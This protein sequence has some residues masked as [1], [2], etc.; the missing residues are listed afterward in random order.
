MDFDLSDMKTAEPKVNFEVLVNKIKMGKA[1]LFTGAGFSFGATNSLGHEPMGAKELSRFISKDIGL[2]ENDNL[3]FTSD[4]FLSKKKPAELIR[5]LRDNFTITTTS[6]T[7]NLICELPWRRA[8]TT[9]YDLSI[10]LAS[11]QSSKRFETIDIQQSYGEVAQPSNLLCVHLNGSIN[12]LTEESLNNSFKLSSSSYVSPDSFLNSEWNYGFKRDLERAD[13]ILFVGYSL[14]D[15]DIQR[16]LHEDESLRDKTYFVTIKNPDVETEFTLSKYGTVLPIGTDAFAE[17]IE[18]FKTDDSSYVDYSLQCFTRYEISALKPE[19]RDNDVEKLLLYGDIS[20]ASV[21][22]CMLNETAV[23][24]LVKRSYLSETI[25]ALNNGRNI[26][27]Y[28]G[29]GN[30]KT[31]LLNEL[32]VEMS[33]RDFHVYTVDDIDGDY[34]GDL[35]HLSTLPTNSLIF[36][37]DYEHYMPV[38]EH[39]SRSKLEKVQVVASARLADHEYLRNQLN[40]IGFVFEEHNMDNLCDEEIEELI[41]IFENLGYWTDRA[42]SQTEKMRYIKRKNESQISLSLIDFL[43]SPNIKNK[44]SELVS[45]F[46]KNESYKS[47]VFAI[48]LCKVIG[49]PATKSLIS[50]IAGN[51]AIYEPNLIN[52]AQFKQLF[53]IKDG[54]VTNL[55]SIFS[56]CLVSEHYTASNVTDNLLRIAAKFDLISRKDHIQERVFKSMLKF[57]FIEKIMPMTTKVGHLQR[58]YEELKVNIPW[59]R[60]N[61]HFWLQY[62]MTYIAFKDYPKVQVFLDQAYDLAKNKRDYHT[63]NI[64]TQQARLWLSSCTK[65]QDGNI[66]YSNFDKAHKLLLNLGDDIYKYRQVGRYL[67]FY[68]DSFQ[69]LSK[70]NKDN[71]IKSCKHILMKIERLLEEDQA[72]YHFLNKTKDKLSQIPNVC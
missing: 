28:G 31:I 56:I 57:S 47:T 36:L 30:G 60:T 35:E 18:I 65:I 27:F 23:P 10:E 26:I 2:P 52:S 55:S 19:I 72:S 40:D 44:I 21:D 12:S 37:D 48:C 53:R 39:L 16:I 38:V 46:Q 5:I 32:K 15:I 33:K 22:A 13:I 54:E 1:I 14:Y 61:P 9:N 8:Y 64:D 62:A 25:N 3:M 49:V 51:D 42:T 41:D 11:L 66:V 59:L 20:S 50:E 45:H 29:L 70:I 63:D 43:G 67:E 24:Y 6:K 71:F 68:E 69:K 34:I 58:Y 4:Y 7:Q 17:Y